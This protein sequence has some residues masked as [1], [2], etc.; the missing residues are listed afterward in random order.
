MQKCISI[1][2]DEITDFN[3]LSQVDKN[4]INKAISASKLAYAPYSEFNVGA[5]L[6]LENNKIIIGNNQ[7]NSSFPCGVCAE[8]VALF[9]ARSIYPELLIKKIAITAVPKNFKLHNPVGPCGLCRQVLMEYEKKQQSD[10]EIL[11]FDTK[12]IIKIAKAKDLLP[13]F[14]AEDKLKRIN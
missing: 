4:L 5:A 1:N 3:L 9:S 13:F 12:K 11:F 7:E 6:I 2:Y 8:R 10:I 14:F